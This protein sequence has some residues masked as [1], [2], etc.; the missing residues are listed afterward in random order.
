MPEIR[1]GQVWTHVHDSTHYRVIGETGD[2]LSPWKTVIVQENPV[3]VER[4]CKEA[5]G[6][7]YTLGEIHETAIG[8]NS[9]FWVLLEDSFPCPGCGERNNVPEDDYL[10]VVCRG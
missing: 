7:Y 8:A 3:L 10:C 2:R 9:A 4:Y 5:H 6:Y 1:I